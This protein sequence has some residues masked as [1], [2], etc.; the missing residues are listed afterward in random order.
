MKLFGQKERDLSYL[1]GK[2][3]KR[4]SL[5]WVKTAKHREER[6]QAKRDPDCIPCYRKYAGY[7]F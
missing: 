7:D 1:I 6:R 3:A 5:K 2:R 4:Y